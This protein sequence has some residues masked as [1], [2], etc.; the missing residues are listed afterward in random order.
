MPQ[1]YGRLE[2]SRD[3]ETS[4]GGHSHEIVMFRPSAKVM[5]EVAHEPKISAQTSKLVALCCKAA[6]GKD[7]FVAFS[8][9][10]LDAADAAELTAMIAAITEEAEDISIGGGD[11]VMEPLVY[12]LYYPIELKRADGEDSETIR[13][14]RFV[15]K[16]LGDISEFLDARGGAQEFYAFMRTFGSLVG[17]QL[18]MSDSIIGAIDFFDYLVIR[19]KILGKLTG[20][21]GRWRKISAS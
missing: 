16:K 15:A 5:I 17:T 21:R 7:D 9:A 6:N 4:D 13:Q 18:P 3:I 14:I 1:E 11:G 10:Q 12:D 20:S 2:L 19:N 8:A